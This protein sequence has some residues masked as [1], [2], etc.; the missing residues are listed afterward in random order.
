MSRNESTTSANILSWVFVFNGNHKLCTVCLQFAY[1]RDCFHAARYLCTLLL[2]LQ[3]DFIKRTY[4]K[5]NL[6]SVTTD[7]FSKS[8]KCKK[9]DKQTLHIMFN[10]GHYLS[11]HNGS[12]FYKMNR[13][14]KRT[15][16]R[17]RNFYANVSCYMHLYHLHHKI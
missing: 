16:W 8:N 5:R 17:G 15:I 10:S 1:L 3:S 6:T 12:I 14:Y 4:L 2:H 13:K 11:D 7:S 9:H